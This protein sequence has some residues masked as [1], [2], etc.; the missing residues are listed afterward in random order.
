MIPSTLLVT[1]SRN[2]HSHYKMRLE[3]LGFRNVHVTSEEKDSLNTVINDLKPRLVL[4]GSCFYKAG[5]PYMMG[6]LLQRFP[7][8]NIAIINVH[9]FPDDFAP[10][11]IWQGAKS[12]ID[13][14]QGTEEFYL[15]LDKV[16]HGDEYI[17]P[18]IRKILLNTEFPEINDKADKRQLEVLMMLSNGIIPVRIG[19]QLHISK[20]T[21]DW[22]IEELKK[23]FCVQ[24][25]EELI[26]M[27]FY[28]DVITKDDLCFF[29]RNARHKA[30]PKWAIAK[31]KTGNSEWSVIKGGKYGSA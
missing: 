3:E 31:Q 18:N 4:L 14:E 17:S 22:H 26:S 25:R 21:V 16:L 11:F 12:Y 30:L 23:V 20:R 2:L 5:T 15:G 9:Q 28:L 10:F 27:A 19:E 13:A 7:K 6:Q 8:L 24:N 29:D 1:R